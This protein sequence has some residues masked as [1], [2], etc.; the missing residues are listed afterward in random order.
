MD[1][2]IVIEPVELS[3]LSEAER[4]AAEE[5][6]KAFGRKV[7]EAFSRAPQ[8]DC[9]IFSGRDDDDETETDD[10]TEEE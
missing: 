7:K 6:M 8:V 5:A 10:N 9:G 4:K 1:K 2:E 3:E